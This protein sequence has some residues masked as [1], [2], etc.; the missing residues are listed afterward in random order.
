[1][2]KSNTLS[3]RLSLLLSR[4]CLVQFFLRGPHQ[5][6]PIDNSPAFLSLISVYYPLS[7][8]PVS[9]LWF[10]FSKGVDLN[11]NKRDNSPPQSQHLKLYQF[12]L[13]CS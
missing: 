11:I 9:R 5:R 13:L 10:L 6:S 2:K 3:W 7:P 12:K 1:M 4:Q 8:S